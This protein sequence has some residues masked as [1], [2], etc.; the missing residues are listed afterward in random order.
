[1]PHISL[2]EIRA[3]HTRRRTT[4]R[5]VDIL[6]VVTAPDGREV[7]RVG[8]RWDRRLR[9]YVQGAEDVVETRRGLEPSQLEAGEWLARWMERASA[10]DE[11]KE[12]VLELA[13]DRGSGKTHFL[14]F[15]FVAF[16]LR[17]PGEVQFGVNITSGQ[18]KECIEAIDAVAPDGAIKLQIEDNRN[19]ATIF[20]TES[21]VEWVSSKNPKRLRQAKR[22]IRHVAINEGQDQPERVYFNAVGAT[23]NVDGLCSIATNRPQDDSGEWVSL[24]ATAIEAEEL[25]GKLLYLDPKLNRR[26]NATALD[27][28]TRAIAAVSRS[29]ADADG[30]GGGMRLA[31]LIAYPAFR[32]I[33]AGKGGHIGDPPPAPDIGEP[34]WRDVTR[35]LTAE[36]M[37]G[38]V[39]FDWVI[40]CDWQT[41]PGICGVAVKFFRVLR[42]WNLGPRVNGQPLDPG[43]LVMWAGDVI[44]APGEESAFSEALD[45]RGYT[46]LGQTPDGKAA[47]SALLVGDATGST[48]NARHR[49]EEPPSFPAM[50]AHGGW[51]VIPPRYTRKRKP[52]NPT[53]RESRNQI[54]LGL[55]AHQLM[56]SPRL[57]D[58]EPGFSSLIESI[59]RAKVTPRGALMVKGGWQHLPDAWRYPWWCFGPQPAPPTPQDTGGFDASAYDRIKG[60]RVLNGR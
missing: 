60:I 38:G 47:P 57:K 44:T 12:I 11:D 55:R 40:G 1:M 9:C 4:D 10:K 53:V 2:A 13:G 46:P 6:L 17:W 31:G 23:R 26:V 8:G 21:V 58:P 7:F 37:G 30:G 22:Q 33:P 18:R 54:D 52:D 48:Q 32:A 29:A 36:K 35:E 49:W 19:P 14:G 5:Y 25:P 41:S 39:G 3:Q 56:V 28:R 59:A 20:V 34:W 45:R 50:R 15:I 51:V 43:T 24:V 16:A 27:K 42:P